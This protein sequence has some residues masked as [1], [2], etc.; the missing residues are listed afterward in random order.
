[1]F[2]HHPVAKPTLW[3]TCIRWTT[4]PRLE[5]E[6]GGYIVS[7]TA[8]KQLIILHCIFDIWDLCLFF[9]YKPTPGSILHNWLKTQTLPQYEVFL[10]RLSTGCRHRICEH[11]CGR[12][13]ICATHCCTQCKQRMC[14]HGQRSRRCSRIWLGRDL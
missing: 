10:V 11:S 4:V 14:K 2:F 12:L 5:R 1:M 7:S 13:L 9:N 3:D 6:P 8:S